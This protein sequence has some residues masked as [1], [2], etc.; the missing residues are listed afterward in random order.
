M[1]W[2]RK[3]IAA[4]QNQEQFWKD[5]HRA[6]WEKELKRWERERREHLNRAFSAGRMA[7]HYMDRL[8]D[9]RHSDGDNQSHE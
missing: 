1:N 8:Y 2:L 9:S 5:W 4:S 6:R 3:W 7:Q